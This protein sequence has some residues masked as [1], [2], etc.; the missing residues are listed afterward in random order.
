MELLVVLTTLVI[1]WLWRRSKKSSKQATGKA[2]TGRSKLPPPPPDSNK[3]RFSP[4]NNPSRGPVN[5][6]RG[7]SEKSEPAPATSEGSTFEASDGWSAIEGEARYMNVERGS[8]PQ[9]TLKKLINDAENIEIPVRLRFDPYEK[10]SVSVHSRIGKVCELG[11]RQVK[12]WLKRVDQAA[13]KKQFYIGTAH[14]QKAS[15]SD[16]IY[17][18]A[19]YLNRPNEI[20]VDV[21]TL[22]TKSLT[23][24]Q[25]AK[26]LL[27][28]SEIAEIYPETNSQVRSQG[29]KSVKVVAGLYSHALSVDETICDYKES[30]IELCANFINE[31]EGCADSEDEISSEIEWFLESWNECVTGTGAYAPVIPSAFAVSDKELLEKSTELS[32]LL[33][34][35]SIVISGDFEEFSREEGLL[36]IK[37]RGGKSPAKVSS[38]T[39]A[40][41]IGSNP[42]NLEL[43]KARELSI[44]VIGMEQFK[45]ML[46]TGDV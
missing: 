42:A 36:A 43:A 40:L 7:F 26:A 1:I 12:P 22:S 39:F 28:L 9:K 33:Q 25:I 37:N 44:P 35:K 8:E 32:T 24:T 11:E 18:S 46:T 14:L 41:L 2:P 13:E 19:L 10:N 21:A 30:L 4:P 15:N 20:A 27:D 6:K 38:K 3:G 23:E 31:C 17:V 16:R 34:G 5:P 29:K 45:T